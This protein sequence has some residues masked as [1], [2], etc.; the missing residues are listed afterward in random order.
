MTDQ[1]FSHVGGGWEFRVLYFVSGLRMMEGRKGEW[2]KR[3]GRRERREGGC[4]LVIHLL[5]AD[6]HSE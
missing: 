5:G 6:F 4:V 2:K 3:R 1:C